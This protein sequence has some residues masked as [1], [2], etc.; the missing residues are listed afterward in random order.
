MTDSIVQEI[1]DAAELIGRRPDSP[2]VSA[3]ISTIS[4]KIKKLAE[5][6][7]KDASALSSCIDAVP[8]QKALKEEL[9]KACED[10]LNTTLA[11]SQS[12]ASSGAPARDQTIRYLYNYLPNDVWCVLEDPKSSS[13][14]RDA[15]MCNFLT[16]LGIRRA[17]EDGLVKWVMVIIIHC[18]H[19][20]TGVW[21][22]YREVYQRVTNGRI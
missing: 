17:S 7:C 14:K 18:E 3:L 10:R 15:T 13:S 11:K 2:I 9:M 8:L 12:K 19:N 1:K 6:F 21:P 5:F 16:K 20:A 4:A 22:S